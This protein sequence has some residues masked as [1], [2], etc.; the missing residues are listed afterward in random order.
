MP[1]NGSGTFIRN[2]NWVND[3]NAAI[4]ITA[5]RMDAD[6][7]DFANGLSQVVTRDGQGAATGILKISGIGA[8][9]FVGG[10]MS[11]AVSAY[12]LPNGRSAHTDSIFGANNGLTRWQLALGDARPSQAPTAAAT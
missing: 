6:S 7:N 11:D 8:T 4:P 12:L 5:P 2:Y 10:G 3:K 1:Y 9:P